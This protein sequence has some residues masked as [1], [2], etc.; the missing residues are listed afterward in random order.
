[1]N[2]DDSLAGMSVLEDEDDTSAA[3]AGS[4]HSQYGT[5]ERR[6]SVERN[7]LSTFTPATFRGLAKPSSRPLLAALVLMSLSQFAKGQVPPPPGANPSDPAC[8]VTQTDL[9]SWFEAGTVTANGAVKPA[10]SVSFPN[11][12]NCSFYKWSE[13][14]F[15][16]LTS[17]APG[18]GGRVFESSEFYNISGLGADGKRT[19]VPN[20]PGKLDFALRSAQ[21]GPRGRPVVFDGDGNMHSIIRPL[22]AADGKMEVRTRSGA[23]V[24]VERIELRDGNPVFL[25]KS[26]KVIG[27]RMAQT[28]KPIVLDETRKPIEIRST[29]KAR[30]GALLLLDASG[31]AIGVGQANGSGVLMAQTGSLVYYAS[32]VNEVY[33]YFLTGTKN[34]GI[35]P[36][37]TR[38][39][40]TQTELDRIT[41]FALSHGKTFLHPNVLA[42]EV[43]S[44]WVESAGLDVN[45]YI[46]MTAT[47]PTYDKSDH[48]HWVLTGSRSAKLAL[49][50]LHVVGSARGN[51]EMIWATFEH[52]DNSPN[53]AYSYTNASGQTVTVVQNTAGNWLFAASSP[54][55]AF[56]VQRMNARTGSKID[57]EPDQTIGPSDTL[58]ENAWGSAGNA[59][60]NTEIIAINNSVLGMLGMLAPADVR[61]NYL[62]VGATWT[63]GGAPPD[64]TNQFGANQLANTTMETYHQPSNCFS[65]HRGPRKDG[66]NPQGLSHMYGTLKP[67]FQQQ[68]ATRRYGERHVPSG[69]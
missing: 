7:S 61:K 56:N 12:P 43:K 3:R 23:L 45:K 16:W 49:V 34:G 2:N 66:L 8:I 58:R 35:T 63:L 26:G 24:E 52:I 65:C 29:R 40:T 18:G 60:R 17:P 39:P 27:V 36:P 48:R 37:P 4:I 47:I 20:A 25:D 41:A 62:L 6:K 22:T 51:P 30:N 67:L 21:V 33:A 69:P 28:G 11:I 64:D 1:M 53:A 10:D 46:T 57:A 38:F 44:A 68:K 13:Q 5:G 55:G 15:L 31:N 59:F 19:L 42:L 32:E 9:A 50:G 54:S 14:M